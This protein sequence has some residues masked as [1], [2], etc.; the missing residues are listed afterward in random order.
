MNLSSALM[1]NQ[2]NTMSSKAFTYPSPQAGV[3]EAYDTEGGIRPHWRYLLHSLQTLGHDAI[4]ERQKKARRILRDDGATYKIYDEPDASQSWQ[5]NPIPLLIHSDE[6]NN[7]ETALVERA[8]LFNLLLQDIYGERSLVRRGVIPPELLFSHQGFLRP[9][10]NIKLPGAQQLIVHGA[11]LVRAHDGQMRVMADRTQAPSGAGYALENRTV[12]NRVFPSL[13]RDSHVH[14]LSLFFSR[15]RQRLQELNPNG[16]I[17]RIVVLTPGIYNEAYFE[18]AYLANYLGFQLVQGG[19][20]SVRNGY[21]WMK[22]LDGLKRVDV[23]LRRVDDVYC[24]PVE[25]KGDSR[26]GVPGLLEVARLGHVAIANPLGSSVLENPALLRYLPAVAQA[27]LG[28]DL[29][30]PSVKTWWCGN[31]DDLEYVCSNLKNLLIKPTY[32]RPGLYEVYGADLD[33][34]KL[35]AWQNRIRKNP[36]QFAAQEYVAGAQTP[37]WHQGQIQP[38]ASVLRTFAVASESSYAV[39]P[40]GLTRVNLDPDK[41]IISNQ[42]GSVSKDTWVLA[43]EPEKQ[44][45]LRTLDMQSSTEGSSALPSRVV[46]NLFWM[47]RYA[48]RAESAMRLLRTVFIQL[49]KTEKLPDAVCRTLLSA[50]THVTATYPGF[51]SLQPELFKNPEP[52]MIA[53]ILDS[54]RLG[55]VANN[56]TAMIEAAEQVKEQLSSDTQRVI[57]DIG[58]ELEQLKLA[59]EP[60]SLSA[61]EEALAPLITTLLAFA[62]LIHESMTRGNGW[63]FMEMGRRLERALQIIN[64]LRSL[65]ATEFDEI[66]QETLIE[67]SLLC[68]E[69]LIPYRR[70][71][72]NGIRLEQALEMLMLNSKNPR[73]LIYQLNELEHHFSDLPDDR[74]I[75]SSEHKLLL[76][77]TT[78]LKLSDISALVKTHNSIRTELDQLLSRLQYLMT[79]VAKAIG[80]RYFDHTEGPQL[81]VKN[82]EWQEQL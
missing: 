40:G 73:S 59:L 14:R 32:R 34:K 46:E 8:E 35:Q 71:Y 23:I 6:W 13:F 27:L 50:V 18:H 72:Q 48:E 36:L 7:I 9:C 28:R 63:H 58:D 5:L 12:M 62:G 52:E 51:T 21:V 61:P 1:D 37:T 75:L 41:K 67:S 57:N 78:A 29:Q 56:L 81:L 49:N 2:G 68:S 26:L 38:R 42:R 80:Q 16:G 76:E 55:S 43:S 19:D 47:G 33:D 82:T 25:L 17:A 24:D 74:E 64:T 3:D 69:A 39:M 31:S 60:S 66:E 11:D 15:L 22:A 77:A 79:Q 44:I 45:S 20:L 30:M 54:R 65:L 10:Q 70:R 53:I 4:E